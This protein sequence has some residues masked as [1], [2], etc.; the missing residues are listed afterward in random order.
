MDFNVK[1]KYFKLFLYGIIIVTTDTNIYMKEIEQNQIIF[2]LPD[3]KVGGVEKNFFLIS[4]Y[5]Y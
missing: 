3:P 5:L 2:F 4:E 1:N